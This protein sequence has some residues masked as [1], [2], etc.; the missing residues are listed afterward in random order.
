MLNYLLV[1]TLVIAL[2][3]SSYTYGSLA[4][5]ILKWSISKYINVILGFTIIIGFLN[6]FIYPI[7]HF[8]V[9]SD[10]FTSLFVILLFFPFLFYKRIHWFKLD[11]TLLLFALILFIRMLITYNRSLAEESFDTVHYLSY[12][13]EASKGSIL[14]EFDVNG[15][16][17]TWL[18]PQD[19]FSSH[20]YV[21]SS[22]YRIVETIKSQISFDILTLTM[23]IIIWISTIFYFILNI[24]LTFVAMDVLQVKDRVHQIIIILITQFFIGS[25]YYNSVFS[26]YGNT[27]RTLFVG[28]VVLLIFLATRVKK[29]DF[30]QSIM[31]MFA[32]SAIMASSGSGY[33]ISLIAMYAYVV[34]MLRNKGLT[35]KNLAI[36]YI[37]F[38]PVILFIM[39]FLYLNGVINFLTIMSIVIAYVILMFITIVFKFHLQSIYKLF[40]YLIFPLGIVVFSLQIN[41]MTPLMQDFFIQR[42]YTDMVWNYLSVNNW[43]EILFNFLL[44]LSLIMYSF[45]SKDSF[46]DR[47]S[48]V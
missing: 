4:Q 33:L 44:W 40:F 46:S 2:T 41:Q 37:L 28:M 10:V 30:Y 31:M 45:K 9:S 43:S 17:R 13:I 3:L 23:P 38:V 7:I 14:T 27:Y 19:D 39:N 20:F 12:I 21:L 16:V 32:S 18:I 36:M 22:L 5:G 8:R 26:F 35:N 15:A 34:L 25:F 1:T 6:I 29:F 48:V 24:S 47:K 42:S 11:K